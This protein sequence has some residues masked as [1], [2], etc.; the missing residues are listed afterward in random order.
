M[1]S[2][3][4]YRFDEL[5]YDFEK[6]L[7]ARSTHRVFIY[8]GPQ[9]GQTVGQISDQLVSGIEKFQLSKPGDRYLF[10]A[11]DWEARAFWFRLFIVPRF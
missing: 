8:E 6:L 2:E 10:A 9:R 7:A 11:H 4:S 1:E 3:W 5:R